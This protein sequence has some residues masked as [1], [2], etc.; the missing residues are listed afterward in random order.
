MGRKRIVL[1]AALAVTLIAGGCKKT[2]T[3]GVVADIQY[4]P[5]K[6]LGTRY[7]SASLDK[8]K[9]ALSQF[10]REKVQF[11]VNLGDTI[12]HHI[13]T[14]DSVMP[15][16][17]ALKAPVYP[18]VG[19]HDFE[20]QE[21]NEDRVLPELGLKDSYYAFAKGSW[22]F[23]FLNGFEL[24]YPFPADETLKR[25]SEALYWRLRA[26]AK[27]Q[28]QR[29]NGGIGLKQIAWLEHQL[30]EAEKARK[31]VLV[32]CHFPVLPEA[33]PNLWNDVEVVAILGR[34]RC[35]KA[36]FCGHNHTG[37]YALRNGIHYLTFQGMVETPD[38]NAFAVV[39][40]E[41]NAIQVQGF[42]RE[43]SRTL[44]ILPR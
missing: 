15:M 26:Q 39:T 41:K 10:N 14:F 11:V 21:G 22:R 28:A 27:E 25:E 17:K 24:R 30:E 44:E 32:L 37:D 1:I 31:N 18:V 20:V 38:Q 6:S 3:F 9:E 5:G 40:L 29:W 12:D 8:L 34:H 16:F 36:Y 19:N 35:V 4:H 13:Q 43:P 7:Y 23:I 33:A 2:I 42:G